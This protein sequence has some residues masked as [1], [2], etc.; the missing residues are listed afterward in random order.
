M[1]TGPQSPQPAP[2]KEFVTAYKTFCQ[3]ALYDCVDL[4]LKL[5]SLDGISCLSGN[6]KQLAHLALLLDLEWFHQNKW[7]MQ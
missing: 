5:D 2:G 7:R 6:L 3:K 1:G 4:L